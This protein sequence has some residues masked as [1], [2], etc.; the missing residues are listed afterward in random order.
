MSNNKKRKT[1]KVVFEYTGI[2]EKD[3]VPNDVTIIQFHSSVTEVRENIFQECRQLKKVI[4]NE[5][6]KKIGNSA[7]YRCR[8]LEHITL[9]STV[10]EI[11]DY[12]FK[13]CSNL[14]EMVLN[15]GLL[16]IGQGS[17]HDC[18]FLKL[19]KLPS[20]ITEISDAAFCACSRLE[21]V[22]LNE[23]LEKIEDSVFASCTSL[24]RITLPHTVKVIGECTFYNCRNLVEIDLHEGIQKIGT[25]AF[26]SCSS[27]ERM[28]FPRTV[29]EI[30]VNTFYNCR[31]LRVVGLHEGIQKIGSLAFHAC[32][33]ERFEFPN[34][35]YRLN[36]I[37]E[38]GKYDD[39]ENKI[40]NILG[41]IVQRRG[42]ELF[43]PA[44]FPS[45]GI[46][47]EGGN[48]KIVKEVLDQIERLITYYEVKE[49][50]TLLELAMWKS[51]I[52]QAEE[53]LINRDA[54]RIDIPGPV[55]NNILQYL[56]FRV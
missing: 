20:T 8:A 33:V 23:G 15:E 16:R 41:T 38:D 12:S 19:V 48:W 46:I 21:T 34:L 53:N 45:F 18:S 55:K 40:D 24:K 17:F 43:I 3:D 56:N 22:I 39:V 51:K 4:L 5:G 31:N 25:R 32:S 37:I 27:L 9:P 47:K 29:T 28:T 30:S 6:L 49:A 11:D 2:E 1:S 35:S 42:S 10:T 7:F 54:H 44:S 26:A 36:N 13:E 50:T 52:D 14:S